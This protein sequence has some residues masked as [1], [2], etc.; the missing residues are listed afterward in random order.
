MYNLLPIFLSLQIIFPTASLDVSA[1]SRREFD[2]TLQS[3]RDAKEL[4]IVNTIVSVWSLRKSV[5]SPE[6]IE[7]VRCGRLSGRNS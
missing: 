3:V 6:T 7:C 1:T 2:R 5:E 4:F